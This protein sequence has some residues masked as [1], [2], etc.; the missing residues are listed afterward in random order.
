MSDDYQASKSVLDANKGVTNVL[1]SDTIRTELTAVYDK[2]YNTLKGHY[3]PYSKFAVLIDRSDIFGDPVFTKDGIN[4]VRAIEFAS[5]MEEEV[6]KMVA[7]IGSRMESAVG[8]GTTSSMMFTCAVLKHLTEHLYIE[9]YKH[10]SFQELRMVYDVVTDAIERYIDEHKITWQ[11]LMERDGISRHK[12]VHKI[13]FAQAYSSSHGDVELSVAVANIFAGT[14]P[15]SWKSMTFQR[16]MYESEGRFDIEVSEGQFEL[17]CDPIVKSVFNK[18]MNTW[19]EYNDALVCVVNDS[20]REESPA[21]D[22]LQNVYEYGVLTLPSNPDGEC[23]IPPSRTKPMILV[24]HNRI[25]S[26]TYDGLLRM[27]RKSKD[28]SNSAPIAVFTCEISHPTCN[29]VTVLKAISGNDPTKNKEH[30]SV[31]SGCYVKYRGDKLILNG[32]YPECS[33]SDDD[34]VCNGYAHEHPYI[35][36]PNYDY[37]EHLLTGFDE[38]ANGY[39]RLKMTPKQKQEQSTYR[40]LYNKARFTKQKVLVIGGNAYDN[41]AMFD[42]VDDVITATKIAMQNGVVPSNNRMIWAGIAKQCETIAWSNKRNAHIHGAIVKSIKQALSDTATD[43]ISMLPY[44]VYES[45]DI[46]VDYWMSHCVD[47]L[48]FDGTAVPID[49]MFQGDDLMSRL[50][51]QPANA[52]IALMTRFGELALKFVLAERIIIKGGAFLGGK[53]K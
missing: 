26:L 30:L 37:F 52:D 8:D 46:S 47:M 28:D 48:D 10:F 49:N 35:H 23:V 24:C 19:L 22:Q 31:N 9:N 38:L 21:W 51:V 14:L 40:R 11:S 1:E 45:D 41:L 33:D 13:A 42:V 39:D 44:G 17:K 29:D 34:G 53:K 7:Y 25:D 18:D 50:I 3:G 32:L 12:A 6:K 20:I 5:P 4:I 36:D 16:R 43:A 2:I 15:E 27:V